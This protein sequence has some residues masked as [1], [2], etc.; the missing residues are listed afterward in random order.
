LVFNPG[1][2]SDNHKEYM[3]SFF[4]SLYDA[5]ESVSFGITNHQISEAKK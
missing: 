5:S 2:I 4:I 3:Y 1:R